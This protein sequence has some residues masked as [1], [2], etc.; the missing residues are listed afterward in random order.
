VG[1]RPAGAL[2]ATAQHWISAPASVG[3]HCPTRRRTAATRAAPSVARP[4]SRPCRRGGK[5][6]PRAAQGTRCPAHA[7]ASIPTTGLPQR[8]TITPAHGVP[9]WNPPGQQGDN[10]AGNR[11]GN[12]RASVSRSPDYS[13]TRPLASGRRIE[14]DLLRSRKRNRRCAASSCP[15][16]HR[17]WSRGPTDRGLDRL[18]CSTVRPARVAL[19]IRLCLHAAGVPRFG[20]SR[21]I[22]QFA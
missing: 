7:R 22:V 10:A 6:R 4:A 21:L 9:P 13:G 18:V 14:A 16:R 12:A 17:R 1:A 8:G 15:T 20:S 19:E 3:S 11:K 5:P 2:P